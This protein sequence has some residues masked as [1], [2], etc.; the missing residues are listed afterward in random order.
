MNPIFDNTELREFMGYTMVIAW[1][2]FICLKAYLAD[3]EY[4]RER[5]KARKQ[6][7]GK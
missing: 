6:G 1:F 2:F 4:K 3:R 7:N 5:E